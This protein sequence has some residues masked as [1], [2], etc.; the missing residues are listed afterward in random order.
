MSIATLKRK[1]FAKYNNSS[2]QSNEGFSI[3]GMYRNQ[4]Y[5]GQTSL[6]LKDRFVHHY[7]SMSDQTSLK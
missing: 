4:G 5:V 6:R 1:T 3:N 2:V 7:Y